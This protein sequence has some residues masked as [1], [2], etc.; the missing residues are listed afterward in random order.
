MGNFYIKT[1]NVTGNRL[2]SNEKNPLD[3]PPLPEPE[4]V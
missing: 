3:I 4:R 1:L 2:F